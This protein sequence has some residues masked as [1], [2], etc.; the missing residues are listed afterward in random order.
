VYYTINGGDP[1]QTNQAALYSAPVT[2][3]LPAVVK[4][5]A[6]SGGVWSALNEASFTAG[7]PPLLITEIHYHPADPSVAERD[8]G[9]SD[10]DQFEFLEFLNSGTNPITL[11]NLRLTNA[12]RFRFA[13]S[14]LSVLESGAVALLVKDRAAFAQRYGSGLP[15][16]GQYD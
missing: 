7:R 1:R 3:P 13:A 6:L 15:V 9:F 8:A 2:L 4:A 16:I 10:A 11:T 12:V 14:D 5:R